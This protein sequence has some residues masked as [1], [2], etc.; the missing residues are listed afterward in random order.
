MTEGL[1]WDAPPEERPGYTVVGIIEDG[2]ELNQLVWDLRRLGVDNENLTVVLKRRDPDEPEPFPEG[3]RYIVVPE[4][5][6]GVVLVAWFVVLFVITGLLFAF[7]TPV[8]GTALFLF[9]LGV[10]AILAV[11]AFM[12]A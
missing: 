10:A 11:A 9:F 5:S 2:A 1:W 4:S 3:T 7:T 8:L 6:W 12:K